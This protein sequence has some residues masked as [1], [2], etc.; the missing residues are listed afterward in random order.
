ALFG[1]ISSGAHWAHVGGFLFGALA[2]V[3][4]RYSGIEQKANKAIEE[5]LGWNNDAELEQASSLMETGQ[6]PAAL[7]LLTNYLATNP[8]SLD[9]WAL[10]RQIYSRKSDTKS[11]LGATMKTCA[12]HLKA[13]QIEA[14]FQDYAEFVDSGGGKMPANTWLELCKGAEQMQEFDRAFAEYQEL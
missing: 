13:H 8:N 1:A 14:A 11:F 2:A 6:L 4:I 7:T 9:A 12:L 10:L 5:E 3:A